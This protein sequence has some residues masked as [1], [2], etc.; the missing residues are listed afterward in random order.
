ML[1]S[2]GADINVGQPGERDCVVIF[3]ESLITASPVEDPVDWVEILGSN[4]IV[5]QGPWVV[6]AAELLLCELTTRLA[7]AMKAV[8]LRT[9]VFLLACPHFYRLRVSWGNHSRLYTLTA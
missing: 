1:G 6:E 9:G 7:P 3:V 8:G 5:V 2:V 4:S